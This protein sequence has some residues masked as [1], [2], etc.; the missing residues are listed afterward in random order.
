M[1]CRRTSKNTIPLWEEIELKRL[2]LQGIFAIMLL[3]QR[4]LAYLAG[5]P[6]STDHLSGAG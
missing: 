5:L 6:S 2:L 3:P 4:T 1:A